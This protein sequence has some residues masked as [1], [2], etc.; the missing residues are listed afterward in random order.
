[1]NTKLGKDMIV[2]TGQGTEPYNIKIHGGDLTLRSWFGFQ[3]HLA[4]NCTGFATE[5]VTPKGQAMDLRKRL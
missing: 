4:V 2:F 5:G 3:K 1:M